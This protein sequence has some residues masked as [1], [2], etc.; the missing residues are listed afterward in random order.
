MLE[1]PALQLL[2]RPHFQALGANR[3]VAR[4]AQAIGN[5]GCQE[6]LLQLVAHCAAYRR[7]NVLGSTVVMID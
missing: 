4:L 7:V 5:R 6:I 2:L 3:R 1:V